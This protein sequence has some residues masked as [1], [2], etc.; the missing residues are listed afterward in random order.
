MILYTDEESQEEKVIVPDVRG[1]SG[2]VVNTIL[3]NAGLNLDADGIGK[4]SDT[5]VAIEQ[6]IEPG[7]EVPRGTLVTVKFSNTETPQTP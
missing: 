3:V 6:S 7:T 2:Q 4:I 5:A 1:K